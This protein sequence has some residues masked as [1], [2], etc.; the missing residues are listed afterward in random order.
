[1]RGVVLIA[2]LALVGCNA[3]PTS[4]GG[5]PTAES[6][7]KVYTRDEFRAATM[8]KTPEQVIAAVGRPNTTMDNTDGTPGTWQYWSKV[9]NPNTGKPD[10]GK[11]DFKGGVVAEVRW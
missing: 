3:K 5:S 11:L 7:S 2:F 4:S 8:G 6:A 1:M 10:D 9:M